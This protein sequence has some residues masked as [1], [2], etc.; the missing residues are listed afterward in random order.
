M[1]KIT[2]NSILNRGSTLISTN[3]VVVHPINIYTK[4]ETNLC[5]GLRDVKNGILHS[6]IYTLQIYVLCN[7]PK[8]HKHNLMELGHTTLI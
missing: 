3:L 8:A 4:F 6:D 5:L 1:H 2:N 7:Y